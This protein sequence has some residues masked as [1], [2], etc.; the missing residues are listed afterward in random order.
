M[1]DLIVFL[2]TWGVFNCRIVVGKKLLAENIS[3]TGVCVCVMTRWEP[4]VRQESFIQGV[5]MAN[6]CGRKTPLLILSFVWCFSVSQ[7]RDPCGHSSTRTFE[8]RFCRD[9]FFSTSPL[10]FFFPIPRRLVYFHSNVPVIK[11]LF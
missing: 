7:G 10:N 5:K 8:G 11:E 2:C 3:R 4:G 1:A 9:S 6:L